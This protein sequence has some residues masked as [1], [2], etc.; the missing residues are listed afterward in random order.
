MPEGVI[1]LPT[2]R[3]PYCGKTVRSP[4]VNDFPEVVCPQHFRQ[5]ANDVMNVT[6]LFCQRRRN[7]RSLITR[8]SRDSSRDR[9]ESLSPVGVEWYESDLWLGAKDKK[10][11]GSKRAVVKYRQY[12]ELKKL[13]A[14]SK[15]G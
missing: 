8:I 6:A 13:S 3:L 12:T 2:A 14:I 10:P 11:L 4:P 9:G 15:R 1:S 7:G 5:M